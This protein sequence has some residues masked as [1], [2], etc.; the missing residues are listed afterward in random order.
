MT[1]LRIGVWFGPEID[2][3]SFSVLLGTCPVVVMAIMTT[4]LVVVSLSI[5]TYYK[6]CVIRPKIM[7]S[8]IL[9]HLG[10]SWFQLVL[11]CLF[12]FSLKLPSET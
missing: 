3:V 9:H 7:G 6:E 1:Y 12:F 10:P 11:V 4:V 5:P 8:Q 2:I